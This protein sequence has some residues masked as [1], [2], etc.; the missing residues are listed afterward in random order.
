MVKVFRLRDPMTYT[1]FAANSIRDTEYFLNHGIE[2]TN[3]AQNCDLFVKRHFPSKKLGAY[4]KLRYG[5]RPI[6]VWT[7][8]PR[9]DRHFQS[10]VRGSLLF[11]S[12]H[13]M[14]IYTGDI[15]LCNY[16][17]Y[18]WSIREPIQLLNESDISLWNK[19]QSVAFLGTYV[20]HPSKF[21]LIKNGIDIN[22]TGI[23]Q[24]LAVTGK[25]QGMVD[26]YGRGWAD[27]I[28]MEDSRGDGW[29]SRKH[30]ILKK[31]KFNICLENTNFD[32]YCTEKI[33]DSIRAHC[34]PIY[35]GK[36]NRIY[37]DFPRESFIDVANFDSPESLWDYIESMTKEDYITR[38]N[39]C[40][41]VYNRLSNQFSNPAERRKVYEK[42]LMKIVER[43]QAIVLS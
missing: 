20:P 35:Y 4:I 15:N 34:L 23:R 5:S 32:Y 19:Q 8:E 29:H 14:N 9:Y 13:I 39:R 10:I 30:E 36:D 6:L 24:Q 43:I 1:P 22:L 25:K 18:N 26:I 33:W 16:T 3:S 41:E 7:H 17:I 37:E 31:Y 28:A 40:I 12:I 27:G 21:S 2:F 11:P 42:M 38:C